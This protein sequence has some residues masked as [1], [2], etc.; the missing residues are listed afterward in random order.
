[1]ANKELKVSG[2]HCESCARLIEN[3]FEDEG[4]QAIADFDKCKVKISYSDEEERLK[5]LKVIALL[6]KRGYKINFL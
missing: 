2:M 5:I 4:I 3:N 1:M 6:R